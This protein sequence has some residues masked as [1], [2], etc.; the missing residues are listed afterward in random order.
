MWEGK[1]LSDDGDKSA[2]LGIR[3]VIYEVNDLEKA[4]EWYSKA[5]K[6]KPYVTTPEYVGFNI[7]G[8]ELGLMPE[9]EMSQKGN[10][11][12]S[13]WGVDNVDEEYIRLERMG[14]KP[15]TPII[16]VGGGIRLG[17]LID[18][19]GNVIGLIYNPIFNVDE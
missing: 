4:I 8:Y 18:P 7:R 2:M 11:V 15:N 12:L 5:F 9:H 13:Y 17:T 1:V 10:N 19:F 14:A 16:A 6:I 3:T